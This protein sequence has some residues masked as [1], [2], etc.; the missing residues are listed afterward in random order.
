MRYLQ[1]QKGFTLMELMIVVAIMAIL[2]TIAYPV[3]TDQMVR[4]K[5]STATG[6]LLQLTQRQEMFY[7]D[8]NRYASTLSELLG[9]DVGDQIIR[10]GSAYYAGSGSNKYYE[11]QVSSENFRRNY[12]LTAKPIGNQATDDLKCSL[13]GISSTGQKT[14]KGEDPTACW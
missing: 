3:Y 14:A 7:A 10:D 11:L 12:S 1:R 5:R 13:I 6:A 9:E 8:N 4:S 2:A